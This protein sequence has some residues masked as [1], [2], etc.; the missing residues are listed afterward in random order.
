MLEKISHRGPAGRYLLEDKSCTLGVVWPNSQPE[1]G[2]FLEC[3]RIATDG[4]DNGHFAMA[5]AETF[6]FKRDPVGA[7]PCILAMPQMDRS[8]LRRR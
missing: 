4:V 6:I 7:A 2:L 5:T 3:S 1:A 8:L